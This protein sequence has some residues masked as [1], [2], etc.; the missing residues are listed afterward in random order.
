MLKDSAMSVNA[1][2]DKAQITHWRM[3]GQS[4]QSGDDA[5]S[6]LYMVRPSTCPCP[7]MLNMLVRVYVI[8]WYYYSLYI[9]SYKS[10]AVE[11]GDVLGRPQESVRTYSTIMDVLQGLLQPG[12][13][14]CLESVCSFMFQCRAGTGL[15]LVA[16]YQ[17]LPGTG[18]YSFWVY[19]I[20][21]WI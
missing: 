21:V 8:W 14:N 11:V 17:H 16:S 9:G 18:R 20:V 15:M 4:R 3:D 19:L 10:I 2:P 12:Q 13:E 5:G 7:Y 6:F 1:L